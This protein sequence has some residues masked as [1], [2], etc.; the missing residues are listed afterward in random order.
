[1][2]TVHEPTVTA[3]GKSGGGPEARASV[4]KAAASSKPSRGSKST[5][6]LVGATPRVDLLPGEVHV[7]RRQRAGV[8][9]AWLGVLVLAFVTVV[10]IIGVSALNLQSAS[11]LSA[12]QSET[13]ALLAQKREFSDLQSTVK[14]TARSSAAQRVGGS[15]EIDWSAYLDAVQKSLPVGVSITTVTADSATATS[16]YPQGT[17]A[18]QGARVATLTFTASSPT[19]PQVP[20]WLDSLRSL[21]GFVDGTAN[22]VTL[23]EETG[24]A[25]T[26]SLTLHVDEGAYDNRYKGKGN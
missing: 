5:A 18:L 20:D 14:D 24:T 26:A 7:H 9:R 11:E 12:A 13:A 2:T 4:K 22:S 25:Y 1:M 15:T 10:A 19:L 21:P 6:A 3:L 16:P 17:S 8:R 23:S